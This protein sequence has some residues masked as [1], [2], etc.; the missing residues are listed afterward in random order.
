ME[1]PAPKRRTQEQGGR[2]RLETIGRPGC[3]AMG[4]A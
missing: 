2:V 4:V 1:V 3:P